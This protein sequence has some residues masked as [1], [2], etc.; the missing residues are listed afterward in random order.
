MGYWQRIIQYRYGFGFNHGSFLHPIAYS[1][2]PYVEWFP[3]SDYMPGIKSKI[4]YCAGVAT[5]QHKGQG[6]R[7]FYHFSSRTKKSWEELRD[8]LIEWIQRALRGAKDCPHAEQSQPISRYVDHVNTM[9]EDVLKGQPNYEFVE[10][11][12]GEVY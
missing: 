5:M 10:V 9:L 6:H 11:R 8:F 2:T 4:Y 7:I 1:F 12:V 3:L